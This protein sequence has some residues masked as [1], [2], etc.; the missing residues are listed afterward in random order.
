MLDII[1][2]NICFYQ[3]PL[4]ISSQKHISWLKKSELHAENMFESKKYYAS[5]RA[6]VPAKLQHD[7]TN[8]KYGE[9][10]AAEFFPNFGVPYLAP[11]LVV[12]KS[13]EKNW[14]ADL[15]Y[16]KV[17]NFLDCHVK[18]IDQE[19]KEKY[20]FSWT[21]QKKNTYGTG[22][23]DRLLS[24]P[25]C[26][27]LVAFVLVPTLWGESEAQVVASAPWNLVF[28][29]LRDPLLPKYIGIKKCLYYKDLREQ[30]HH[31]L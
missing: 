6:A 15:P 30:P 14:D 21:F 19:S 7:I 11:D 8:G 25:E 26:K 27:D 1:N 3:Q 28:P 12:K 16:S 22:G 13:D 9:F 17:G 24:H 5:R 23:E 10:I 29:L 20:N 4:Q 18:T 2:N 31:V